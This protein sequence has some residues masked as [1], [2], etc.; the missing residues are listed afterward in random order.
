MLF[1]DKVLDLVPL[2]I[3]PIL[4]LDVEVFSWQMSA[5]SRMLLSELSFWF[6]RLPFPTRFMNK[7]MLQ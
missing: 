2:A 7:A 1:D 3:Y 5:P 4:F 6:M